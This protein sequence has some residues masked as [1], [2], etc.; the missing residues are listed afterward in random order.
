MKAALADYR[1]AP[2]S[3][4]EKSLLAFIEQV[5]AD[6]VS[7][8]AQDIAKLHETGWT[9][10]AI[11][12]AI[13]VCAL[14]NFYNRWVDATGVGAMPEDSCRASGVRIAQHGYAPDDE[15]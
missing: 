2:I 3:A 8:S 7:V 10:E 9:D 13:T 12:D 4:A 1:T 5:N 15:A 14:F 6:C 11:Y